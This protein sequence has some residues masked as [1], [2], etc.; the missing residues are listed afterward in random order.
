[1]A[2]NERGARGVTGAV[3]AGHLDLCGSGTGQLSG[4]FLDPGCIA[5][6]EPEAVTA[7]CELSGVLGAEPGAGAGDQGR[8]CHGGEPMGDGRELVR[9]SCGVI[10]VENLSVRLI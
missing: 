8:R 1:M 2:E 9:E 10:S 6:H 5:G 4:D 3:H 7:A